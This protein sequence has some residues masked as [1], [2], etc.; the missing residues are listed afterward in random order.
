VL[1]L[2]LFLVGGLLTAISGVTQFLAVTW[3]AAPPPPQPLVG[4]QRVLLAV[5]V[6]GLGFGREFG[7]SP[8]FLGA[9]GFAVIA[10]LLLLQVS[11]VRIRTTGKLHRF[12]P[13]I[14]GYLIAVSFG[15][16]GCFAGIV[17]ATHVVADRGDL[18]RSAHLII[19]VFGLVG[20]VVAAT[21]PYMATPGPIEDGPAPHH[22]SAIH[23]RSADGSH[24]ACVRVCLSC[25]A[26]LGFDCTLRHRRDRVALP[27]IQLRH[28]RWAG[29]GSTR[30]WGA[31][32]TGTTAGHGR[33]P[34][35]AKAHRTDC[36]S[37]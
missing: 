1:P 22:A 3:S 4:T 18:L 5:G 36:S 24:R 19:N 32:V 23:H 13:A 8:V 31:L 27:R 6:L 34:A 28:L 11:L 29:L 26:P 35:R 14:D 9:A 10:S 21:L 12:R 37:R 16:V 20:L 15:L 30:R 17:M 33:T 25:L 7:A 2:H